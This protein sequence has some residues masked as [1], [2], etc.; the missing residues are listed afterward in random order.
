MKKKV[1][2]FILCVTFSSQAG[3]LIHMGH[4]HKIQRRI[5]VLQDEQKLLQDEYQQAQSLFQRR[6]KEISEEYQKQRNEFNAK[7]SK[8]L[9]EV[10]R[11][12]SKNA[13][14]KEWQSEYF[15]RRAR[16]AFDE[17]GEEIGKLYLYHGSKLLMEHKLQ[18]LK[19]K[20]KN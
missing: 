9:N 16:R 19:E 17:G 11:V 2:S 20:A 4:R 18:Q 12:M 10:S 6:V 5:K 7:A 15:L 14:S 13:L 8:Y 1:L 3:P